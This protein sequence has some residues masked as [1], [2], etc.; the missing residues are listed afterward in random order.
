MTNKTVYR[1]VTAIDWAP[2]TARSWILIEDTV[3]ID[4]IT[5]NLIHQI[6]REDRTTDIAIMDWPDKPGMMNNALL[7]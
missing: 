2:Q 6:K 5:D 1:I 7:N 4:K 3:D